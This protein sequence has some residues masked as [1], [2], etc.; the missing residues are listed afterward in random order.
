M[1]GLIVI[2][3]RLAE[4]RRAAELLPPP[5]A[6]SPALTAHGAFAGVR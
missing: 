3:A 1:T 6:A 5:E 4:R 2:R